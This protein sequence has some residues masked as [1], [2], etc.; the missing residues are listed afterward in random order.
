[1]KKSAFRLTRGQ[2]TVRN[3]AIFLVA[4]AI[5]TAL[6]KIPLWIIEKQIR[7]EARRDGVERIEVLWAGAIACESGDGGH[8]P[9]YGNSLPMVLARGG[10]RLWRGYLTTYEGDTHFGGVSCCPEPRGPALVYLAEPGN[11]GIIP[12][13]P[14][15]GAWMAAVDLPEEVTAVKSILDFR[16]GG[17]S[18]GTSDRE[19]GSRVILTTI[20]RQVVEMNGGTDFPYIL[21][22][23]NSEGTVLGQ[24]RGSLTDQWR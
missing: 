2:K 16:G 18:Y 22:R 3:V 10:G 14:L 17:L 7:A 15:I 21:E 23:L 4:V 24:V 20:P 13:N 19:S 9:L 6:P 11:G 12:E 1:M 8:F 5:W